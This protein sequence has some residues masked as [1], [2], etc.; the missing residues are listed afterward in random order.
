MTRAILTGNF[1]RGFK[2]YEVPDDE[3]TI[4]FF[5]GRVTES[6]L[7]EVLAYEVLME[8]HNPAPASEPVVEELAEVEVKDD[9][10]AGTAG[11]SDQGPAGGDA[12]GPGDGGP[13]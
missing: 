11:G 4:N 7:I 12:D 1:V 3:T 6:R 5:L 10:D 9:G 8:E 2:A 13:Q